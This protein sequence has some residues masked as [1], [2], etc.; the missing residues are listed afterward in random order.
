MIKRGQIKLTKPS[1]KEP[2][3]TE[4]SPTVNRVRKILLAMAAD[5]TRLAKELMPAW[6]PLW[7]IPK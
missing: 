4:G 7:K 1:C 3:P 6:Y 2:T 5:S